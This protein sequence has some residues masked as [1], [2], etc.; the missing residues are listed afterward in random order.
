MV[1]HF[2]RS[3]S[4]PNPKNPTTNSLPEPDDLNP[5]TPSPRPTIH[6]RAQVRRDLQT[7]DQKALLDIKTKL[8]R[9]ITTIHTLPSRTTALMPKH[10]HAPAGETAPY[11]LGAQRHHLNA[12]PSLAA[13][14][15][16][17][18]EHTRAHIEDLQGEDYRRPGDGL[19]RW[20]EEVAGMS[21]REREERLFQMGLEEEAQGQRLVERARENAERAGALLAGVR[22]RERERERGVGRGQRVLRLGMRGRGSRER[23]RER[24]GSGEVEAE[25]LG[26]EQEESSLEEMQ[27][28]LNATM[29]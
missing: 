5:T 7:L 2:K 13:K 18:A 22:A 9:L 3:S 15:T 17:S 14:A 11:I 28:R 19:A 29:M 1:G 21:R 23:E 24:S 8:N 10:L 4:S 16:K 25:E 20:K 12:L 27:K 6:N 26:N